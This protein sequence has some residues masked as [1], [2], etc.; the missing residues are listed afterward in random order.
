MIIKVS[1][2]ASISQRLLTT[3]L[4]GDAV[5]LSHKRNKLYSKSLAFTVLVESIPN[6]FVA[7]P[8]GFKKRDYFDID[9][10]DYAAPKVDL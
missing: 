1:V 2:L 8:F 4:P 3:Q 5:L 9:D 7:G 10:S 6:N